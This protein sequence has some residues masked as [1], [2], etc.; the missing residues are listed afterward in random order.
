MES[1]EILARVAFRGIHALRNSVERCFQPDR[2]D[3]GW[4]LIE[5][6]RSRSH[7]GQAHSPSG[8]SGTTV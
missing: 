5:T 1:E 4:N 7:L 3:G 2:L 6:V 8:S